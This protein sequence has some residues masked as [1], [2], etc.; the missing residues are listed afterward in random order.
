MRLRALTATLLALCALAPA[1]AK[2]GDGSVIIRSTPPGATITVAGTALGEAPRTIALPAGKHTINL[3]LPG[4]LPESHVVVVKTGQAAKLYV[5][6]TK[7][8]AGG[9]R[10]RDDLGGTPPPG[11]GTVTVVTDPPGL[12][13]L[14]NGEPVDRPTPVSFDIGPGTYA[15][16]LKYRDTEVLSTTTVVKEGWKVQLKRD[17]Q[18]AVAAARR[19]DAKGAPDER[20][21]DDRRAGDGRKGEKC[22]CT[23]H[24]KLKA[25]VEKKRACKL[26]GH[27][28]PRAG[29]YALCYSCPQFRRLKKKAK[30][31]A[32][33]ACDTRTDR[34]DDCVCR[35]IRRVTAECLRPQ[36]K[37]LRR[38]GRE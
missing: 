17:L 22:Q 23:T 32:E 12:K 8:G 37:C 21:P 13:V 27:D 6:L 25:C 15:T 1:R 18:K 38:C 35:D 4:H 7:A 10:V 34:A 33:T 29:A 16:V 24:A 3:S 31:E 20:G 5:R 9:L 11:Q 14:V 19:Q 36:E 26:G 2:A 28:G 30:G